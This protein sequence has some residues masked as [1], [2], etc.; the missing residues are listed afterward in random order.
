MIFT[1][2]AGAVFKVLYVLYTYK[3]VIQQY[4]NL[5]YV[6]KRRPTTNSIVIPLF[7]FYKIY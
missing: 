7:A 1:A 5:T 2:A 3:A 6:G 4:D